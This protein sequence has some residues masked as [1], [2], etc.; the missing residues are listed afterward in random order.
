MNILLAEDHKVVR[1]GLRM[2]LE[3]DKTIKV[4]A[5]AVNGAQ[6]LQILE[7]NHQIDIVLSD[8]NMPLMDGI[9]MTV[10][11]KKR[12]S[13][14]KVVILSMHENESYVHEAFRAGACGYL[15]KNI[16]EEELVFAIKHINSCGYYLCAE[17]S[18]GL[19]KKNMDTMQPIHEHAVAA[20]YTPREIEVLLLIADGL[21]NQE[22]SDKLFLSKRTIEGHRQSLIDKTGVRNTA[23]LV[24]YAIRNGMI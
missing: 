20:D 9:A 19:L 17:L 22:M 18:I 4:A 3:T 5:E 2:L 10:E 13:G 1:N 15:L 7:S 21:T 24:S 16:G 6:V 11:L 8:V 12:G 14:V 23:N